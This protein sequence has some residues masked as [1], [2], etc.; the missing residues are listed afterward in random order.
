[1][2]LE[3]IR[4][5]RNRDTLSIHSL[6][7]ILVGEPVSTSPGYALAIGGSVADACAASCLGFLQDLG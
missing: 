3:R 1:M 7:H 4:F 2:V 5:L 6:A